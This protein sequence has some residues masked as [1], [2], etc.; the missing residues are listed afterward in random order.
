MGFML[1]LLLWPRTERAPHAVRARRP[2]T[3]LAASADQQKLVFS[4]NLVFSN[5]PAAAGLVRVS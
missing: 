4:Q 3:L 1:F 5:V 2:S